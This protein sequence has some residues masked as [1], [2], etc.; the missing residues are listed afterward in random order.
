[1][2]VDLVE[3]T[4]D[5]KQGFTLLDRRFT[6]KELTVNMVNFKVFDFSL[7]QNCIL[8][9]LGAVA[10]VRCLLELGDCNLIRVNDSNVLTMLVSVADLSTK[11]HLLVNCNL[12]L[13][14]VTSF[15]SGL[16]SFLVL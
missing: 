11:I 3:T 14:L 4:V 8:Q 1:M 15:E 5:A 12:T 16:E 7:R 13:D 10:F 6:I 9:Q 2:F